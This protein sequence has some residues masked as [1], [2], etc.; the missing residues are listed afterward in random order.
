MTAQMKCWRPLKTVLVLL[1]TAITGA[2]TV[3]LW[4]SGGGPPAAR[5]LLAGSNAQAKASEVKTALDAAWAVRLSELG[6]APVAA[7]IEAAAGDFARLH[8]AELA[9]LERLSGQESSAAYAKQ[10]TALSRRAAARVDEFNEIR[11]KL[12][13][14]EISSL[15][16]E[17][18]PPP[19]PAPA[20]EAPVP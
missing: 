10:V 19:L 9:E 1:F 7:K 5:E 20:A 15:P 11:R 4:R 6:H 18:A 3:V 2:V 13:S 12:R 16:Q 17:L 14:G 8:A